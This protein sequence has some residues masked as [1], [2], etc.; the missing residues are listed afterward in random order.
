MHSAD[1]PLLFPELAERPAAVRARARRGDPS[2]SA[3]AAERV[4]ASGVAHSQREEILGL[5][6]KY[7][8]RTSAELSTKCSLDRWQVARRLPEL[9]KVGDIRR[10]TKRFCGIVL[11]KCVTWWPA[12]VGG[13]V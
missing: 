6:C 8:G 3:Q 12:G 5:V 4:E 7:P 11:Q 2:S 13:G 10:G 1:E 9:A